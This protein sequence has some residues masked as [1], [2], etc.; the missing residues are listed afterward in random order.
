[1]S[2]SVREHRSAG[3][4][5][6]GFGVLTVSDTRTEETDTSGRWIVEALAQV[7]H[8]VR[9]RAIARDEPDEIRPLLEGWRDREGLDVV[10]VTGGTGIAPRDRT[11][12]TVEALLTTRLPGYGEL[13]RML[14]HAEI[15]PAAMLSR[16]TGGL[17]GRTAI[18]VMP[19]STAAVR[20]AMEK[21]LIPE[22]PHLVGLLRRG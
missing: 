8:E 19:G 7:G 9:A 20:L 4:E 11:V 5:R 3:P 18:F 17:M 6:L 13:F 21:L 14:S 15:G 16:A 1:L 2:D 10:L 12:E 22:L